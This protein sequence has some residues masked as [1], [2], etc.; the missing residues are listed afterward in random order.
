[1]DLFQSLADGLSGFF[2]GGQHAPRRLSVFKETYRALPMAFANK[3]HLEMGNKVILPPSALARLTRSNVEYPMMFSLVNESNSLNTHVGVIEFSAP[4]GIAYIPL[5]AMNSLGLTTDQ[6]A[7]FTSTVLP[8]GTYVKIQPHATKFIELSNPRAVLEKSLR[9]YSCLTKG[10]TIL[11]S[12]ADTEFLIDIV[13]VK[14][15]NASNAISLIDTDVQVEF[16]PPKDYVEPVFVPRVQDPSPPTPTPVVYSNA[17]ASP[18]Q[19]ANRASSSSITAPSTTP[20]S[21]RP[22]GYRLKDPAPTGSPDVAS[23][24]SPAPAAT[25]GTGPRKS[26]VEQ[27][28]WRYFYETDP[29]THRRRLIKRE[30]LTPSR[31]SIMSPGRSLQ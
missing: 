8:K 4:E 30:P 25:P 28:Q 22:G 10:E 23:A 29:V 3:D 24:S 13:D 6:R 17:A 31:P 26:V 19:S 5:T 1:M 9:S 27:G 2:N 18:E 7:T 16:D 20:L 15:E 21:A 11:I 14:P 12:Y